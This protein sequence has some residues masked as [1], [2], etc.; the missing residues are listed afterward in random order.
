M[1]CRRQ[2]SCQTVVTRFSAIHRKRVWTVL[3]G[4]A[5]QLVTIFL[6]ESTVRKSSGSTAT[7][8]RSVKTRC[9]SVAKPRRGLT[10]RDQARPARTLDRLTVERSRRKYRYG[11]PYVVRV[12]RKNALGPGL[13]WADSPALIMGLDMAHAI[14]ERREKR[15]ATRWGAQNA[16]IETEC[17]M[18]ASRSNRS[19]AV[20]TTFTTRDTWVSAV[21]LMSRR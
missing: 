1:L 20:V 17:G 2:G 11:Q 18:R 9:I 8:N 14:A 16:T 19:P 21:R 4:N 13:A 6:V 5:D 7:K 15:S 12:K 3:R 10:W